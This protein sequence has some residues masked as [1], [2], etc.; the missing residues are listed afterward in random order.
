[1]VCDRCGEIDE[2]KDNLLVNKKDIYKV[3]FG[4]YRGKPFSHLLQD[5]NYC[6][7]IVENCKVSEQCPHVILDLI[8]MDVRNKK[9]MSDNV[10]QNATCV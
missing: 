4:K 8:E 5:T 7:W 9:K 1:M 10:E 2:E 3:Q 6:K